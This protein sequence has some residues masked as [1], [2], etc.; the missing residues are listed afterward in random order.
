LH[1]SVQDLGSTTCHQRE[2][3]RG[4]DPD[5]TSSFRP[6][7]AIRG[8]QQIDLPVDPPPDLVIDFVGTSAS[9]DTLPFFAACGVPEVWRYDE[10]ADRVAILRLSHG[11]CRE[12]RESAALVPLTDDMLTR[13]VRASHTRHSDRWTRELD[14]WLR[15]YD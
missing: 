6:A 2:L 9:V 8:K 15:A 7:A 11:T 14:A 10:A 13:L 4:V 3:R 1:H 12:R 5:A